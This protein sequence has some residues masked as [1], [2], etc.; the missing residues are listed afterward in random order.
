MFV[1]V[2]EARVDEP[3]LEILVELIVVKFP[4]VPVI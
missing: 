3:E 1:T 4:V 2:V